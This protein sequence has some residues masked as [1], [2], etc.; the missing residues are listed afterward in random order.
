MPPGTKVDWPM[1]G[2][3]WGQESRDRA[4]SRGSAQRRS[5]PQE[6]MAGRCWAVQASRGGTQ[7]CSHL[8]PTA[9]L[10]CTPEQQPYKR[11]SSSEIAEKRLPWAKMA[12]LKSSDKLGESL[13][14]F[15]RCPEVGMAQSADAF[16][17]T[18]WCLS[19]WWFQPLWKILVSWDDYSQ[20]MDK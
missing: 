9:P 18:H 1:V 5:T 7:R 6:A 8:R 17:R 12:T 14:M 2:K 19:G 13:L 20:Y 16:H 3:G 15:S 11:S 4:T 10:A